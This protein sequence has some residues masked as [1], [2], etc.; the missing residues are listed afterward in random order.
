VEYVTQGET[1]PMLP[2]N[3]TRSGDPRLVVPHLCFGSVPS[4]VGCKNRLHFE[5]GKPI[6]DVA[7]TPDQLTTVAGFADIVRL[8]EPVE[9]VVI[10]GIMFRAHVGK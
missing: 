7:R 10:T 6:H 8:E 2:K 9:L 1:L 4:P 3:L 5:F